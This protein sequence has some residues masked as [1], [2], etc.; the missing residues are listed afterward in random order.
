M[1]RLFGLLILTQ[2][3]WLTA[4]AQ[5]VNQYKTVYSSGGYMFETDTLESS[6]SVPYGVAK[7]TITAAFSL[8]KPDGSS[9]PFSASQQGDASQYF[10]PSADGDIPIAE[11]G[12]YI[13]QQD[14][15]AVCTI[16]GIFLS[17][18][19]YSTYIPPPR[20]QRR[21][22]LGADDE[23]LLCGLFR[24]DGSLRILAVVREHL[25][26]KRDFLDFLSIRLQCT[27]FNLL[28]RGSADQSELHH[29][30]RSYCGN[31]HGLHNHA[32]PTRV[33]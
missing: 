32:L 21:S 22:E 1:K 2:I 26:P 25:Q 33:V 4:Y 23:Y 3:P 14:D 10:D 12:P 30:R 27:N 24:D 28:A 13:A 7:H 19:V 29:Q 5:T 17:D 6:M 31:P 20:A 11:I 9:T 8:K 18:D 16:A 15:E